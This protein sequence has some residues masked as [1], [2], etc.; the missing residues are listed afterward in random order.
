MLSSCFFFSLVLGSSVR[1]TSGRLSRDCLEQGFR[2][3]TGMRRKL[4]AI[5]KTYHVCWPLRFDGKKC[6]YPCLSKGSSPLPFPDRSTRSNALQPYIDW[7]FACSRATTHGLA[8]EVGCATFQVDRVR[9]VTRTCTVQ[10]I[11][12]LLLHM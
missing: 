11:L 10:I 7:A 12:A 9:P 6:Q 2:I 5:T 1:K 8:Y 3:S 4:F